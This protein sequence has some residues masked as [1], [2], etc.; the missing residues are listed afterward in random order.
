MKG[1]LIL[2]VIQAVLFYLFWGNWNVLAI[3]S[4]AFYY[5]Y[6]KFAMDYADKLLK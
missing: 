4:F 6:K 5:A 2:G 3:M 1:L